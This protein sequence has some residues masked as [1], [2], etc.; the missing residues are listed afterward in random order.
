M[1]NDLDHLRAFR[2]D[3]GTS[4]PTARAA[5]RAAL[6]ERIGTEREIGAVR[7]RR[8]HRRLL[9]GVGG[10]AL[11]GCAAVAI[12]LGS[13]I[14]GGGVQPA[15]ATA[16][17]LLR[18]AAEGAEQERQPLPAA[19]VASVRLPELPPAPQGSIRAGALG[20]VAIA[21]LPLDA[22]ALHARIEE[23]ARAELKRE[24]IRPGLLPE[25]VWLTAYELLNGPPIPAEL[26]AAALEVLAMVPGIDLKGDGEDSLG[27]T[28]R[29]LTKAVGERSFELLIDPKTGVVLEMRIGKP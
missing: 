7:A 17:Q 23:A 14:G 26:R 11:A 8:P 24:G 22:D 21:D 20:V 3:D 12:A 27:R 16:A 13:G 15:P 19:P 1:S 10:L 25:S 5:A 6:L 28:G 29:V 18:A 9:A 4:D 2:A